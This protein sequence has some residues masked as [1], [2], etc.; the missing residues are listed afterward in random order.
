MTATVVLNVGEIFKTN[1]Y[2]LPV[3]HTTII[4]TTLLYLVEP[5]F[6]RSR[7]LLV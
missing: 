4:I 6:A 7:C 1:G 3:M 5:A 2:M